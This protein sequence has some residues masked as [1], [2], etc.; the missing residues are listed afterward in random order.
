MLL[1]CRWG[2]TRYSWNMT[3]ICTMTLLQIKRINKTRLVSSRWSDQCFSTNPSLPILCLHEKINT[4]ANRK[5]IPNRQMKL[6]GKLTHFPS[7]KTWCIC[8]SLSYFCME[9]FFIFEGWAHHHLKWVILKGV[10]LCTFLRGEIT[11]FPLTNEKLNTQPVKHSFVQVNILK[12]F[13]TTVQ[14]W[15]CTDLR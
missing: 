11:Q 4:S 5:F 1:P 2:R 7:D 8:S 6:S 14:L 3:S 12:G 13:D 9:P 10:R 15:P